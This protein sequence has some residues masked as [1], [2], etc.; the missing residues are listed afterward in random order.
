M[1][2]FGLGTGI[3]FGVGISLGT[4]GVREED[5]GVASGLVN[6]MQQVGGSIGIA[7]LST[8]CLVRRPQL[9]QREPRRRTGLRGWT[10]GLQCRSG[11]R[12][13]DGLL[14]RGRC[15]R[16]RRSRHRRLPTAGCHHT[17]PTP[18]L[19]DRVSRAAQ[20]A[21]EMVTLGPRC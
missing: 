14:D 2:V 15:L 16:G 11:A 3:V 18:Y 19:P 7:F 9:R 12:L 5:A 4:L 6:T 17:G 21:R 1:V 8:I 10:G 20:A 13:L